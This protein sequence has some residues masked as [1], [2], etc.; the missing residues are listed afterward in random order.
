MISLNESLVE[1]AK[2]YTDREQDYLLDDV[3]VIYHKLKAT[4]DIIDYSF[5]VSPV[6]KSYEGFLKDFFLFLEFT[7]TP[8]QASGS[9]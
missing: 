9:S 1:R 6:V 7:S 5:L 2:K 4:D 3:I 8:M